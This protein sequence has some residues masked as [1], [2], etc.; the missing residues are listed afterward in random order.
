MLELQYRLFTQV[1]LIHLCLMG[2]IW[3]IHGADGDCFFHPRIH[4]LRL[5]GRG[6]DWFD[7]VSISPIKRRAIGSSI[8]GNIIFI[9]RYSCFYGHTNQ[10]VL[11]KFGSHILRVTIARNASDHFSGFVGTINYATE[12]L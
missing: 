3:P 8:E 2:F 12:V 11:P 5:F 4:N 6:L 1:A 10:A 7:L 9:S